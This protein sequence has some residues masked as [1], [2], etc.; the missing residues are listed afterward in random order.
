MAS[1]SK[2]HLNKQMWNGKFGQSDISL[3]RVLK[4]KYYTSVLGSDL[5]DATEGLGPL[6]SGLTYQQPLAFE[7]PEMDIFCFSFLSYLYFK[8]WGV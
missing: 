6:E 7:V 5:I 3:Y 2:H 4:L 8:A 1:V